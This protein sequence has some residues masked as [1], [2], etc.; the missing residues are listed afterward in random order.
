MFKT[1]ATLIVLVLATG[2]ATR[3]KTAPMSSPPTAEQAAMFRESFMKVSPTAKVGIV[4]AILEG[5]S[6]LMINDM[7]TDGVNPGD[8]VSFVD[9]TQNTIANGKVVE[10]LG[11]KVAASYTAAT[12]APVTGDVAVKF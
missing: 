2:C 10:V 4:G 3:P 5:E 7:P 6:L 11:N 8:V 9:S 1:A 12:R